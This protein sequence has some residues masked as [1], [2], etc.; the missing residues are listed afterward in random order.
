MKASFST[1]NEFDREYKKLAKKFPSLESDLRELENVISEIPTG[2]GKNFVI[3][4]SDEKLKIVKTRVLCRTLRERSIRLIY[5]YNQEA[6]T[7]LYI[8]IYFK[9]EKVNE[10]RERIA[11]YLKGFM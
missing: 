10:D 1:T 5:A 6:I 2:I 4:H 11:E 9:G 3:I 7:F 8:E